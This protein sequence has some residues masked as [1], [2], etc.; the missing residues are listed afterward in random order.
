MT[1]HKFCAKVYYH[2]Y[3]P[4]DVGDRNDQMFVLLKAVTK[5]NFVTTTSHLQDSSSTLLIQQP[6]TCLIRQQSQTRSKHPQDTITT[7]SRLKLLPS[8]H[9]A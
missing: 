5:I 9:V 3:D 1:S 8:I 6:R 4:E 2:V 7:T